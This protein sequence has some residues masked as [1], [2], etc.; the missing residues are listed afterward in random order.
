M[1]NV[2][3]GLNTSII[4]NKYNQPTFTTIGKAK[5]IFTYVIFTKEKRERSK[6]G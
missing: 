3:Y 2:W 6:M 5:Q 1:S 4:I